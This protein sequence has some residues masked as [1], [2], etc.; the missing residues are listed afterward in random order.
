M[1]AG[2]RLRE[3]MADRALI[4]FIGVYDVFSATLAGRHFDSLFVSG[5]GF[6]ASHYG[7]PDIGFITWTD[8]VDYVQRLRTVLPFHHLLVDI[9]DGYCDPEVACH[10]VSVLEAAGA[11]GVVLEDQKRPRRCGHFEGKQIM[12]LD[13]YLAKLRAILATRRDM[14]VIARTDASDLEDIARRVEAFSAAGADAVLVDGL[15]SL[16]VVRTLSQRVD[17]PF[18]FNQIAGGKSP[19]CTQSE[20]KDAGV[21]LVIYSTPCLFA[22]QA[23]IEEAM[24]DLKARDGTLAGSRVGV[25]DCT[26]LLAENQVRRDTRD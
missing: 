3:S 6:A 24:A 9:D 4:P 2:H 20:L 23:A 8:I 16:D 22:A 5:F 18:C 12:D 21:S 1:S 15:T 19:M 10:V 26:L 13:E 25:K 14:V 7:L 11:S 17:R